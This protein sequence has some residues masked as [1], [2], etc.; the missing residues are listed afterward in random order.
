MLLPLPVASTCTSNGA[1]ARGQARPRSAKLASGTATTPPAFGGFAKVDY[2]VPTPIAEILMKAITSHELFVSGS[3]FAIP[4]GSTATT[5][6][7]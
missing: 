7:Y 5:H 2:A 1:R 6:S 3:G 4:I